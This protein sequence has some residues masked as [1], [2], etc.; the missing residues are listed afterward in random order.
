MEIVIVRHGK[1]KFM[2]ETP[3]SANEFTGWIKNYNDS[4]LSKNSSPSETTLA[5]AEECMVIVSSTLPRSVDSAKALKAEKLV[6][7]D[8]LFIE[9]GL[10]S[11]SWVLLKLSPKTWAVIFRVLWLFGYSKKSESF[12]MAKKRATLAV[13]QLTQLAN[14]YQKVLFVGHGVF[15]RLLVKE[16]INRGWLGPKKPSSTYW[17]VSVYATDKHNNALQPTAKSGS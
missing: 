14:E 2:N 4:G 13:D 6:L 15:N 9:A 16:L 3:V 17:S 8:S 11:A 1:P 10:P 12:K 5:Y 7:S